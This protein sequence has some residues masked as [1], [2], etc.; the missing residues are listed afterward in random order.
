[1]RKNKRQRQF[2]LANTRAEKVIL[3]LIF[4]QSVTA[5]PT[6]T[7]PNSTEQSQSR[8]RQA[9]KVV[10][11][12]AA[13]TRG[14]LD[15]MNSAARIERAGSQ[16]HRVTLTIALL[17][18]FHSMS[19]TAA[20]ERV[21]DFALLDAQGEFHQLS[22]YKHRDALV[23]LTYDPVCSTSEEIQRFANAQAAFAEANI[24]FGL[25]DT[26]GATRT[27]LSAFSG[28][29]PATLPLLQDGP[30]LVA[31]LLGASKVGEV[32]VLNPDRLNLF[33]RGNSG[34][35]LTDVLKNIGT[36]PP[37]DTVVTE[38]S[39]CALAISRS[40]KTPDYV[41]DVAPIIKDNCTECHRRGGV[42]P[43]AMDSY[44]MLL[45][46]SPM[47]REVVLNKR[48][49]PAQ[50]DPEYGYSKMAR[51]LTDEEIETLVTWID[52]RA[53]RG[54]GAEDPLETH[55]A[56][57]AATN[58]FEWQLGEPDRIVVGPSN[59]I[60]ST[61]VMD[62]IYEDVALDFDS[63]RWLRAIE[64]R[65]G[66]ESVLH[67]LMV[68]VTA[69]NEDFWGEERELPVVSRR[70][71]EGYAPGPHRLIEFDE[72]TGV[73]IPQG[74]KLSLQFHY[75]TNG[76][77]TVD[78]TELGL[79]FAESADSIVERRALAVGA[80]FELPAEVA[81]FPLTAETEIENDIIVTGVRARMSYRGKKM[82]FV[83]VDPDGDERIL[84]SVPAYNYGWQPHY[85]FDEPVAIAAGSRL[86]VEGALD[87]SLSNP[88]NPDSSRAVAW[89]LESWEE[90]FTGYF[91]YYESGA[92]SDSSAHSSND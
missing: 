30:R 29:L 36:S 31:S 79:Y 44:I 74:H 34:D 35:A 54:N 39:G 45:G 23:L 67:H 46:W 22:R 83:S 68:F 80:R 19:V 11:Y 92:A 28:S 37:A 48:M 88:T 63:D 61:G 32:F 24:S 58:E 75:V 53:P 72:G 9:M 7:V 18:V 12:G 82:R 14:F 76:Q 25:L 70:F 50:V 21:S 27:E 69:P 87:N 65:P 52:A 15:R 91:T 6:D 16:P 20:L 78:T 60:P 47:I 13:Q 8:S 40:A 66:D 49:P 59:A 84:F 56:Q 73:L 10:L 4:Q 57:L 77:S 2:S 64:T 81:D 86:R 85:V 43:F 51:Y 42:G 71:V 1:M 62:Y 55:A 38:V 17:L 90:M 89:G 3:A 5:Q 33:Y 26:S 41:T